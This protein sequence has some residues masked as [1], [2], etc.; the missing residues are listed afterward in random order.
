MSNVKNWEQ[1]ELTR[2]ERF[3]LYIAYFLIN[4]S[5]VGFAMSRRLNISQTALR[6]SANTQPPCIAFII[7]II[8]IIITIIT[9]K[10]TCALHL[11]SGRDM[12]KKYK[13]LVDCSFLQLSPFK[14]F[15]TRRIL[16]IH[17]VCL[18]AFK[19]RYS[20]WWCLRCTFQIQRKYGDDDVDEDDI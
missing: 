19:W 11:K 3:Q 4:G 2:L 15:H 9:A 7:I 20:W 6:I 18:S 8:K 17:P 10:S 16:S 12:M 13:K 14:I 5:L 1:Y